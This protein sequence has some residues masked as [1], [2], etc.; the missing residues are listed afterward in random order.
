[1]GF[2]TQ[3]AYNSLR[4]RTASIDALNRTN[5]YGYCNCGELTSRPTP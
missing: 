3:F 2:S 4:Q 5:L 1:M